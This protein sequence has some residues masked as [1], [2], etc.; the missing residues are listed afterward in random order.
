MSEAWSRMAIRRTMLMSL[1]TGAE[2]AISVRSSRSMEVSRLWLLVASSGSASSCE[3]IEAIDSAGPQLL[4]DAL[5]LGVVHVPE[6]DQLLAELP[7]VAVDVGQPVARGGGRL[8]RR[9]LRAAGGRLRGGR[10]RRRGGGL[11]PGRRLRAVGP[12]G[13]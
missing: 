13:R 8:L 10:L 12:G 4:V 1:R 2:L 11:R 7:G 3:M 6:V 5:E 9:G